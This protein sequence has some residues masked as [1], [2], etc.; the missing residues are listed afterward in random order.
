ME[1]NRKEI[2]KESFGKTKSYFWI[3]LAAM[4]I[5]SIVSGIGDGVIDSF[6]SLNR[7]LISMR[8]G[9]FSYENIMDRSSEFWTVMRTGGGFLQNIGIVGL[10]ITIFA[11]NPLEVGLS[12]LFMSDKPDFSLLTD[13]FKKNYGQLVKTTFVINLLLTLIVTALTTVYMVAVFAGLGVIM[14]AFGDMNSGIIPAVTV[15]VYS[16]ILMAAYLFFVINISY[17][18]AM[19]TYI[20][21]DNPECSFTE[22][23]AKSRNMVKGRK[24]KIFAVD[25]TFCIFTFAAVLF[26]VVLLTVGAI[27]MLEGIGGMSCMILGMFLIIPAVL[28]SLFVSVFRKSAWAEIYKALKSNDNETFGIAGEYKPPV[29]ENDISYV[30]KE[31]EE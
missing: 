26:P 30:K 7:F 21:A 24:K 18:F 16:L 13:G 9:L 27:M 20:L 1:I 17:N 31:K 4:L 5:F 14:L 23:Y 10:L 6:N 12:K 29:E 3:Y 11:A 25:L 28:I 19:T 8:S 22:C 2:L 15:L